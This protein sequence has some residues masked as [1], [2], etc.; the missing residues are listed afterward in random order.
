MDTASAIWNHALAAP[1]AAQCQH[2]APKDAHSRW[3]VVFGVEPTLAK[4]QLVKNRAT[5]QGF[6]KVGVETECNGYS[7]ANAGFKSRA[8]ALVLVKQAQ[9]KGFPGAHTEDS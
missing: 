2:P 8:T 6:T 3:E 4:A 9:A 7:V 1:A 5:A